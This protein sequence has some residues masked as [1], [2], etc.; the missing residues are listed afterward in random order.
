MLCCLVLYLIVFIVAFVILQ[1][2]FYLYI[3][4]FTQNVFMPC[5]A[6]NY[7][8]IIIIYCKSLKFRS[9]EVSWTYPLWPAP[10]HCFC[11]SNGRAVQNWG[12]R[13]K[14]FVGKLLKYAHA[15]VG[16]W[17]FI[18]SRRMWKPRVHLQNE[19]CHL[20]PSSEFKRAFHKIYRCLSQKHLITYPSQLHAAVMRG[21]NG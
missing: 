3:D 5:M 6:I 13:I 17:R 21:I 18:I 1:D 19:N 10:P 20:K 14:S 9:F 7:K 4:P 8:I 11:R 2:Y 15:D 16:K 12:G